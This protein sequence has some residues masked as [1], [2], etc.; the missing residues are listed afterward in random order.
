MDKNAQIHFLN[1]SQN[2][3]RII[4]LRLFVFL[5]IDSWCLSEDLEKAILATTTDKK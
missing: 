1:A 5:A 4:G 2:T 3:K